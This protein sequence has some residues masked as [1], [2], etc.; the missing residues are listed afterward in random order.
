MIKKIILFS[1]VISQILTS[2]S[3]NEDE[4]STETQLVNKEDLLKTE[5]PV[6]TTLE[7]TQSVGTT[8]KANAVF[9][10]NN[11]WIT[12]QTIRIRF[13][14]GSVELQ[15]KIKEYASEWTFVANLNFVYV[16][17]NDESD[18]SIFF[19]TGSNYTFGRS[20][21]F[22]QLSHPNITD[23]LIKGI[24]LHEF[25][26]LLGLQHENQNPV[27]NIQWNKPVV[28]DYYQNVIGWSKDLVDSQIFN[29]LPT[30]QY[31]I[32]T[33]YD[34]SSVMTYSFPP[35]FTTDGFS[36]PFVSTLSR[37]DQM[38]IGKMF[39]YPI[40]SI[41]YPWEQLPRGVRLTS[42]NGNYT[43]YI[44][45]QKLILYSNTEFRDLGTITPNIKFS[46]ALSSNVYLTISGNVIHLFK[47]NVSKTIG[48]NI[49]NIG[50]IDYITLNNSGNIDAVINGE[51]KFSVNIK[52]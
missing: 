6:C 21:N 40:K 19:Q 43:L 52:D 12:G 49:P 10:N 4:A 47:G 9:K 33:Q 50:N 44:R 32:Y 37:T 46:N 27:A 8:S 36:V 25:G 26:H 1:L 35:S 34:S 24:T 7:K 14:G 16:G 29:A 17:T 18:V 31:D 28:Y 42:P 2:C 41:L 30:S 13:V 22:G 23:E 11:N 15:N 51:V 45:S 38:F 3:N 48:P 5:F 39:P 20:I